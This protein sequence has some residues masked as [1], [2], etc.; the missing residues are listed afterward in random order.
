M[1]NW[2][3]PLNAY[4]NPNRRFPL[5]AIKTF[6]GVSGRRS[7]FSFGRGSFWALSYIYF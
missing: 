2:R 5:Y 1:I 7:F 4:L 6:P 3:R